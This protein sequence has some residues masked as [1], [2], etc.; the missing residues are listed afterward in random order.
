LSVIG[1]LAIQVYQQLFDEFLDFGVDAFHLGV[2]L[3]MFA[4][5]SNIL[6]VFV[7]KYDVVHSVLT[8]QR[9][10]QIFEHVVI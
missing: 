8:A 5:L 2:L 1:R 7:R 10:S 6:Q 9:S 3:E 4:K